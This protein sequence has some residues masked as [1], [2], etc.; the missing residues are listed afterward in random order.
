M[1][2]IVKFYQ[3]KLGFKNF[4]YYIISRIQ[5][6]K[7]GKEYI[8]NSAFLKNLPENTIN[9]THKIIETQE[10]DIRRDVPVWFGD[11]HKAKCKII[12]YGSEPRATNNAFNIERVGKYV[13][14]TPFGVER[15]NEKSTIPG[16]TQLKY[17]RVFQDIIIRNDVFIIFSD[18][19]KDYEVKSNDNNIN[20]K[21][22]LK[23]FFQKAYSDNNKNII[24][25]EIKYIQPNIILCLGNRAYEAMNKIISNDI[26]DIK[27]DIIIKKIRHPSYGGEN[28]ARK[29]LQNFLNRCN[30]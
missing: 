18:V 14:A 19:V 21:N 10:G 26:K 25:Q 6:D 4:Y 24:K 9:C 7:D 23:K 1:T 11:I 2:E 12:V 22:A 20:D 3:E 30:Q 13:Y 28:E 16:R 27:N 5:Q 8:Q 29:Q 17:F 15:W